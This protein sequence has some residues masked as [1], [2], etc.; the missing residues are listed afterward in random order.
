MNIGDYIKSKKA[1]EAKKNNEPVLTPE[2]AIGK[3]S[4]M[5]ESDLMSELFRSAREGR[6]SGEL[7][8]ESLEEFYNKAR[9]FLT[10]EQAERMRELLIELKK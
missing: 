3:Y 7:T 8:D 6:E 1:K 10:P 5:S 9:S 2:E 4:N